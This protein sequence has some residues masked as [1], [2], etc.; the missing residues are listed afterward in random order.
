MTGALNREKDAAH[1]LVT[2][3]IDLKDSNLAVQRAEARRAETSATL[4]AAQRRLNELARE[5][6]KGTDAYKQAE[7]ALNNARID[8]SQS[9]NDQARAEQNLRDT[10]DKARSDLHKEKG[11]ID[12]ASKSVKG[13]SAS[14]DDAIGHSRGMA[15][16]TQRASSRF[17]FLS[18]STKQA[19]GF[20]ENFASKMV[21]LN[22][23]VTAAI[24]KLARQAHEAQNVASNFGK[25][26]SAAAQAARAYA[27]NA[28]AALDAARKLQHLTGVAGDLARALGQI[29]SKKTIDI[30]ETV[31]TADRRQR[32]MAGGPVTADTSYIVGEAGPELFVPTTNGNIVPNNRLSTVAPAVDGHWAPEIIVKNYFGN[33]EMT[34]LIDTRVEYKN[35]RTKRN[36]QA[37]TKW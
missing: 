36:V 7:D 14:L 17:G 5:G 8:H 2:D 13:F 30:Y 21:D 18:K 24:P 16:A 20:S 37:G 34:H 15:V 35:T 22:A 29:P 9:I 32:K 25:S 19:A 1:A 12:A 23:K 33:R 28:N 6:K 26:Q 31:H 3:Q 10:R 11:A 4:T 27:A